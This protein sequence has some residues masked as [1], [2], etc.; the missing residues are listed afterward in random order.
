MLRLRSRLIGWTV[1]VLI[2]WAGAPALAFDFGPSVVPEIA[3]EALPPEARATLVRIRQGGP[4]RYRQDGVVFFNREGHLPERPR[5]YYHEFTVPTPGRRDRG[6]QRII[7]G[8][9]ET[10]DLRSSNEY[11]YTPDHYRSFRRIRE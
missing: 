7:A 9:G 2:G 8:R 3:G 1:A 10:N 5:G 6:A 4:F 11:Y